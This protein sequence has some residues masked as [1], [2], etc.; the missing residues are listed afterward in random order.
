MDPRT[1]AKQ[2][3]VSERT[4]RT[5]KKCAK[6]GTFKKVGRPKKFKLEEKLRMLKKVLKEYEL[7]GRPGWRP[8][9]FALKGQVPTRFVQEA[10]SKIKLKERRQMLNRKY[11]RMSSVKVNY[12]NVIWTQDGTHLGRYGYSKEV[13]AQVIKDRCTL[14]MKSIKV[15]PAATSEDVIDQLKNNCANELPLVWMTDNGSCYTSKEVMHF[16]DEMKVIHLKNFP[17]TPEHNGACERAIREL[18]TVSRLGKGSF[19][20]NENEAELRIKKA[21]D[22]L[23]NFRRHGS[24]GFMTS[25][26]REKRSIKSDLGLMRDEL[27]NRYKT[28]LKKIEMCVH[29]KRKRHAEREMIFCL[30]EEYG[31]ITRAT[32]VRLVERKSE[33]VFL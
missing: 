19:L 7:Q 29:G 4:L 12:A 3:K 27:Y 1:T 16:L 11:K 20:L 33:E 2:L 22:T 6:E 30:L 32:G 5:W 17:R 24:L 31:L 25:K 23:D 14:K 8:V 18:K 13:Q 21:A 9:A 10:L 15:G 26:E 28:E